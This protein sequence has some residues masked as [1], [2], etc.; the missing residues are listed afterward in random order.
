MSLI[1]VAASLGSVKNLLKVMEARVAHD[2]KAAAY[3]KNLR[4]ALSKGKA[5]E[6]A[7]AMNHPDAH[8]FEA[9]LKPQ[10]ITRLKR[11]SKVHMTS[12]T[13]Y[14]NIMG[15]VGKNST[16][17][18][19][20]DILGG[21]K[22]GYEH[23]VGGIFGMGKTHAQNLEKE[24]PMLAKVKSQFQNESK[25]DAAKAAKA[26]AEKEA[27]KQSLKNYAIAGGVGLAGAGVGAG[28]IYYG[29]RKRQ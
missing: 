29:T 1:K 6:I 23:E 16:S 15:H 10:D 25:A 12:P 28:A 22:K 20:K 11:I 27:K 24:R 19:D 9:A 17:K 8:T 21:F 3:A 14:N 13:T 5:S 4:E 7:L 18:L 2:P 26:E